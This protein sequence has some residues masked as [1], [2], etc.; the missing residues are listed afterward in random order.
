MRVLL[1]LSA[2]VAV[3]LATER[4]S[5]QNG[6]DYLWMDD[7]MYDGDMYDDHQYNYELEH[8]NDDNIVKTCPDGTYLVGYQGQYNDVFGHGLGNYGSI[9][10]AQACRDQCRATTNCAAFVFQPAGSNYNQLCQLHSTTT[11]NHMY[12]VNA[13]LCKLSASPDLL[14]MYEGTNGWTLLSLNR[15]IG[16]IT[17]PHNAWTVQFDFRVTGNVNPNDFEAFFGI[18]NSLKDGNRLPGI[19]FAA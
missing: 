18:G 8:D 2:L 5:V 9:A 10:T 19:Y 12:P 16:K 6:N 1:I 11:P 4:N 14:R 7:D 15:V 13:V 3:T 17:I